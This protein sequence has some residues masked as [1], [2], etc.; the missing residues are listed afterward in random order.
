[1]GH[2]RG[3]DP[4]TDRSGPHRTARPISPCPD[5][6]RDD[7]GRER[8]GPSS[9]A[10]RTRAVAS[11]RTQARALVPVHDEVAA[12]YI[13]RRPLFP[14][15]ASRIMRSFPVLWI[16]GPSGVGKSSVGYEL[17]EQLT[18]AGIPAAYVDLDPRPA[19]AQSRPARPPLAAAV[20]LR[21]PP[22][23]P[24]RRWCPRSAGR[25]PLPRSRPV[26][27]LDGL[28]A[29]RRPGAARRADPAPGP[30]RRPTPA[31]RRAPWPPTRRAPPA[32]GRVGPDRRGP[33][34]GRDRR[35]HRGHRRPDRARGRHPRPGRGLQSV[36]N[37]QVCAGRSIGRVA[38][39]SGGRFRRE[40]RVLV[41]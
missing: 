20:R 2:H 32:R 22:P 21:S 23:D 29:D 33:R 14:L 11:R 9:A 16:C 18:E 39:S 34:P 8:A 13:D 24:L 7:G 37:L 30:G 25:R 19:S 17:F 6:G 26:R 10:S 4:V 27:G 38:A 5:R 15:L 41:G 28:P 31:R 1:M 3:L 35:S 40:F 12:V 36:G